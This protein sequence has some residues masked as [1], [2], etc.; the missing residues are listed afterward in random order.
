MWKI[1]PFSQKASTGPAST[2][3]REAVD[4]KEIRAI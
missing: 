2:V 4:I 1:L 3:G